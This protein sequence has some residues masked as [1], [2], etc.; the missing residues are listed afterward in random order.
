MVEFTEDELKEYF[1]MLREA[2]K[3]RAETVGWNDLD[4]EINFS[5]GG[6]VLLAFLNRMDLMPSDLSLGYIFG[7]SAIGLDEQ[8]GNKRRE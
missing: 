1:N 7:N 8:Y 3:R 4:D 5:M 2:M 6:C